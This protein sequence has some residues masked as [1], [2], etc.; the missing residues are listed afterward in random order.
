[1]LLGSELRG[2]VAS[3]AYYFASDDAEHTSRLDQLMMIQG[4]RRYKRVKQARYLPEV[5]TTFED[6]VYKLPSTADVLELEDL[7]AIMKKDADYEPDLS[8]LNGK[9]DTGDAVTEVPEIETELQEENSVFSEPMDDFH[10]GKSLKKEVLVEGEVSFDGKSYG[11]VA[12]TTDGGKFSFKIPPYYDKG[13]LFIKAYN[14]KDSVKRSMEGLK[15]KKWMDERAFPDYYVKRDMFFPIFSTPY[16]WY[17]VNSPELYF[18]DEDDDGDIPATSKLA[19]NHTLQ[20]VIVKARRRGKRSWDMSKPAIVRDIYELYNDGP[21]EFD[22]NMATTYMFDRLRLSRI[23]DVRVYTDY[24]LRTDSGYV[25]EDNVA[26]VVLDFVPIEDDGTRH[27]YR[28]RRYVFPGITYAEEFY[29]PDYSKSLPSQPA[30]YR[31]TLYWN[32]NAR[33]DADGKFTVTFYNNSRETRVRVSA[34]GVGA[35]GKLY[36]NS[37]SPV[38]M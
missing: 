10:N 22:V 3:P 28:D 31:R 13:V 7:N 24:E 19:G 36:S 29:S 9:P 30:D 18:F 1:M 34:V 17:Q 26:A 14:A 12:K 25:A 16:S 5:T 15:D 4:W 21:S 37:P 11:V 35:N 2:F 33:P 23:K 32:P 8:M 38:T 20:T 27:S 6:S